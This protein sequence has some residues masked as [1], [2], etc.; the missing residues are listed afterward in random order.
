MF[1][2]E[3]N[4]LLGHN[5]QLSAND[6]VKVLVANL[7]IQYFKIISIEFEIKKH[8]DCLAVFWYIYT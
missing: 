8:F 4:T 2:L 5:M 3:K 1:F 6:C 7:I